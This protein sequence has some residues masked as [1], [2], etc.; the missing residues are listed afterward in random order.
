MRSE[1]NLECKRPLKEFRKKILLD[2]LPVSTVA[3][4]LV[5][6]VHIIFDH[7]E[8]HA[9]LLRIDGSRFVT[10]RGAHDLMGSQT[11]KDSIIKI[12][13]IIL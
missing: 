1:I 9:I 7:R 11:G 5:I 6:L 8:A 10:G 2:S 13:F 12:I 3:L 4:N